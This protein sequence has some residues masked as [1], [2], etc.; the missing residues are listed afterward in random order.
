MEILIGFAVFCILMFGHVD[1]DSN[2]TKMCNAIRDALESR[3][4]RLLEI[5]KLKLK[6]LQTP[7]L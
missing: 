5:E 1:D 7:G 6:M 3:D 4:R 2:F